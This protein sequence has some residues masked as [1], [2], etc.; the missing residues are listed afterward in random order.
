[1]SPTICAAMIRFGRCEAPQPDGAIP[2][3]NSPGDDEA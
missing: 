1:V 2:M 3:L